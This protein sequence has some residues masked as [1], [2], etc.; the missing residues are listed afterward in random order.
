MEEKITESVGQGGKNKSADVRIVQSLLIKQ[1]CL[2]ALSTDGKSNA[3]G[4]Y[5]NN[6]QNAILKFQS[7]K[8]GLTNPDGRVDPGGQTM[9]ALNGASGTPSDSTQA[10]SVSA[11]VFAQIQRT[12]PNGIVVAIYTDYNKTGN[13]KKDNNNAEFPRAANSYATA[14]SAVG[15]DSTGAIQIG[16]PIAIKSIQQITKVINQ[17][18]DALKAAFLKTGA[19]AAVLPAYTKIKTLALLCH[20]QPYGLNLLGSSSYNL[21][22]DTPAEAAKTKDFVKGIRAALTTDVDVPLF[23]CHAGRE[24]DGTEK[25]GIWFIEEADKQDGSSSFA[26]A[27]AAELGNQ[28]SVYGHLSA[29]HTVDNYSARVFGRDAGKDATRDRGGIHIFYLL[30]P[31]A[32]RDA[33]TTRLGKT[34]EKIRSKMQEHYRTRMKESSEDKLQV[35]NKQGILEPGRL[36]A[37]MFTDIDRAKAFLQKD[38]AT[39]VVANPPK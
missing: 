31:D 23:A 38:W 28:S 29:G 34:R 13:P 32:F 15:I 18:H 37:L 21:R 22:I 6:T 35:P 12:F 4:V 16:L 9:K 39:W 25:L 5:G 14:Y 19:E 17:I 10:P 3:D 11:A 27:L 33:E 26:S 30:Y 8:M 36:G 2:A 20:G 7:E 24:T 1:G